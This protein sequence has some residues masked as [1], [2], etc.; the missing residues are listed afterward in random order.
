[1]LGLG[2]AT[3]QYDRAVNHGYSVDSSPYFE[4]VRLLW[5][6]SEISG[7]AGVRSL[8]TTDELPFAGVVLQRNLSPDHDPAHALMAVVNGGHYVHAHASGMALELFGAGTVLGSNAGP[9][10][11]QTDEHENYRRLYAGYNSVIVN[12]ASRSAGGWVNLGI[13]TVEKLSLE[14][15]VAAG[16]VS[17]NHSFTLT[18]FVDDKGDAAEA[19]QERLVGIVRTSASSGF[20]VDVFRSRSTLPDQY[21]DY[22]YHN[23][24]DTL[25]LKRTGGD[26]PLTA[27]PHRFAP[28]AG[29]TWQV[30][31][32]YLY[33]GWHF[34]KQVQASTPTAETVTAEFT[35]DR[36]PR[37][38]VRMVLHI[39]GNSGR[40]YASALAPETK[41]APGGYAEQPTPVLIVRQSGEAWSHPFGV[42]YEPLTGES[43]TDSIQSVTGLESGGEFAG[44]KV[45]S[46]A[47][48]KPVTR[49]I[50]VQPTAGSIYDNVTLGIFFR[51]RY[52]IITLNAHG[53]CTSL[54]LGEGSQLRYQGY[55]LYSSDNTATAACATITPEQTTVFA[56]SSAELILPS[57]RKLPARA[58][59]TPTTLNA[60]RPL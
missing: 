35:A 15:A 5:F 54:Y 4:P 36:L 9:G 42:I 24:G 11:Y 55:H 39:P 13:N 49:Y 14:P 10:I 1:L 58:T 30:N 32:S 12:G 48:G 40:E 20:Y 34:F 59:P 45:S 29:T 23:L 60:P 46:L 22:V 41:N 21:H 16:P 50:L 25:V 7:D 56:N 51:G 18:R 8:R 31:R 44:F 28:A 47:E 38:P 2:I 26:L 6:A 33:P 52:G 43:S 27:Q 57:G 53:E 3:G 17:A 37:A 19:E